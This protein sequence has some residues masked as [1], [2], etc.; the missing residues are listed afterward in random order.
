MEILPPDKVGIDRALQILSRGGVIAHA[1]ET[2]YGLACDMSNPAAVAKVFRIKERPLTQPISALFSSVDQAKQYVIWND[3]AEELATK[4]LPGPLTLILPLLP[5]APHP[6]FPAV[7]SNEV[8][9]VRTLGIRI[10]SNPLAQEL[11]TAFGRPISTTSA[12]IHGQPN[13]YSA[14]DMEEQFRN[15]ID[16]PDLIL[17][18]G[19]LP[20]TPPSTVINLATGKTLRP[21]TIDF[22]G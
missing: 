3:R 6:L 13:P 11:V 17:D 21:G 4:H 15:Q 14:V 8:T 7:R 5:D 1:T 12:N 9:N 20:P 22:P 16:R 18:S 10:S 19:R 2:C